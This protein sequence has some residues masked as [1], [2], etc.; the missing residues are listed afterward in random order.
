[1]TRLAVSQNGQAVGQDRVIH[2][3]EALRHG[4]TIASSPPCPYPC[5]TSST[6][7]ARARGRLKPR[8]QEPG[9]AEQIVKE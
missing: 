2:H 9:G 7:F 5:A 6:Y 1:M 8:V 4:A 3:H